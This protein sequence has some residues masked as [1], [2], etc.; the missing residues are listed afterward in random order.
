MKTHIGILSKSKFRRFFLGWFLP[1]I[2]FASCT[3]FFS[4]T[5]FA[6]TVKLAWD[7]NSESD[8]QGYKIYYKTG[9][10][11]AP[12]DGIGADQGPSGIALPLEDIEDVENPAFTLTGLPDGQTYYLVITAYNDSAES[13]YSN[14][15]IFEAPPLPPATYTITA[16]S[17]SNGT[18]TPSGTVSV[19]HGTSKVYAIT[20]DANYHIIDVKVDGSSV[21]AAA[22]YTF[23]NITA[24]HTISATFGAVNE[25]PLPPATYTITAA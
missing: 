20:P 16:A 22:S 12:Y 14:E 11:G 19:N 10:S 8:L 13:G 18:I 21:G 4:P 23:N 2:V 9:S 6:G 3:L 5:V 15:V 7:A 17:A 24:N 25:P 1:V